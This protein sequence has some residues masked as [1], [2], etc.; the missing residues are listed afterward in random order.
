MTT[1]CWKSLL[2]KKA[3]VF[4][5]GIHSTTLFSPNPKKSVARKMF[6]ESRLFFFASW[7]CFGNVMVRFGLATV[8]KKRST[9][10]FRQSRLTFYPFGSHKKRSI[11]IRKRSP[12]IFL[13]FA[14]NR[15]EFS[16]LALGEELTADSVFIRACF[17][18]SA[19]AVC[20]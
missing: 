1:F 6:L 18:V 7:F 5:C 2:E 20:G 13:F 3:F 14:P 10:T 8:Q 16:L 9:L 19:D 17:P 15:H 11:V 4:L 12:L